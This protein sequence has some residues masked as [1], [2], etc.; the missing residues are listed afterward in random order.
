MAPYQPGSVEDRTVLWAV[1]LV[2][3]VL[4]GWAALGSIAGGTLGFAFSFTAAAT[5]ACIGW[6]DRITFE[7][8]S[9]LALVALPAAVL[10]LSVS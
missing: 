1:V 4:V 3:G 9:N 5:A 2:I 6:R 10:G 8:L 7:L